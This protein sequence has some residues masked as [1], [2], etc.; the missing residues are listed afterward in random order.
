MFL[1]PLPSLRVGLRPPQIKAQ[2]AREQAA[3]L[4][5][6]TRERDAFER[7]VLEKSMELRKLE[8]TMAAR[9]K[10]SERGKKGLETP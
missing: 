10:E 9:E 2:E 5:T 3:Q 6:H 7:L 4:R 8:A 1:S